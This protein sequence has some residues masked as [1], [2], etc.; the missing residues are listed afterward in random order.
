[1]N[2][3]SE[4]AVLQIKFIISEIIKLESYLIQQ[5]RLRRLKAKE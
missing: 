3:K 2:Q 4:M 1:M 5:T